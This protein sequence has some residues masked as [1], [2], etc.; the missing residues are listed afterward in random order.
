MSSNGLKKG[1]LLRHESYRIEHILGQGGF[2]ITYLA[3]DLSL[4]RLVA[5]KEF[6]PKDYCDRND[7]TSQ[8]TLGTQS[9][10]ELV[11]KLKAKF[12]KEARNIAKFDH[13]GIIKIHT[14]FEENNTAYYVMD[15]IEGE[16]ASERIKRVGPMSENEAIGI[17]KQVGEALE[18][19]HSHHVNHLD[20]KPA[21]IMLRRKDN[22]AILIDFGLSKQYDA[23]G[24]QT[25]TTPTGISHGFAPLEQYKVGGVQEFSPQTDVYSL[26][27]TLYYMVT[28]TI[29][30]HATD[31]IEEGISFP[32]NF[33][34][35]L[36]ASVQKAMSSA[37]KDR[38]SGIKEFT[39]SLTPQ[40]EVTE[41]IVERV[42]ENVK[43]EPF[44]PISSNPISID[45]PKRPTSRYYIVGIFAILIAGIIPALI[46]HKYAK[47]TEKRQEIEAIGE[48]IEEFELCF[49]QTTLGKASYIGD[50]DENMNPHGH[51]VATWETGEGEKYDGEWV[52]GKMEGQTTYTLRCGDTFVGTFKDNLYHQGRY[53]ISATGEYFEG[54]FKNGQPDKGKWY[55]K[56]G[57]EI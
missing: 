27:A 5:I 47:V 32:P 49:I 12:L 4:D 57:N 29:P 19:I 43:P 7:T 24:N 51:G 40:S 53:T 42:E 2:G 21:N 16:S 18:Y 37:R 25:S 56:S 41:I 13:P 11:E 30:P 1:M 46:Y 33:P 28:G 26:A 3:T 34:V 15:Y 45:T 39:S 50:Y 31:L 17:V 52:H 48:V 38:N 23:D 55:D 22:R 8:V 44:Q 35:R 36:K 20:I 10:K 6:F 9:T 54:T 14:A